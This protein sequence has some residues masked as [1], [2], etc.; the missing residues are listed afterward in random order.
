MTKPELSV[1]TV[2]FGRLEL[3]RCKLET[4][5]TQ[6]LPF[7]RF[8]LVLCV[9]GDDETLAVLE[10]IELPFDLTLLPFSTTTG[11]AQAR[12][13]CVEKARADL[14]YFSD[15]DALL[16][17]DTL[18]RHLVFHRTHP[19]SVAV[20][21][22]DWEDNGEVERMRPRRVNYWNLH[23]IN[24]SL[25]RSAFE[26]VGG[27]SE[28]VTGYGLE[29]VLLGYELVKKGYTLVALPE[30]SVRHIGANPMRG[31]QP[32]KAYSAGRN[33]VRVVARYPELA[34]RLG[35]HPLSLGF[36]RV[37]LTPP[38]SLLWQAV[39]NNS[40]RYERAYLKCA[41]EEKHDVPNHA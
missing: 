29:D 13:A 15:D 30:V 23:G 19:S 22:V 32:E 24:T 37:A 4:L 11:S 8:E 12:N 17:P 28:W 14:L 38:L 2:T 9:N 27:F 10:T 35:V 5:K 39:D 41:L 7:E 26:A 33:A 1:I 31:L 3:L 40:F 18:A 36:K 20:G 6:T 21:G 25:L 34:F 16:R